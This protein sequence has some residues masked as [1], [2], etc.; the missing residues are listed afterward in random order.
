MGR[1]EMGESELQNGE[2]GANI[3]VF[4]FSATRRRRVNFASL[5]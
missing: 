2:R 1:E 4:A 5:R 3:S